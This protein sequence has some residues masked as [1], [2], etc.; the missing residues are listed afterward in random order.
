LDE[1]GTG[2]NL[3]PAL[4]LAGIGF[5]APSGENTGKSQNVE[6]LFGKKGL[7]AN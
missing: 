2:W 3:V 1:G 7:T 4:F 6:E 5:T